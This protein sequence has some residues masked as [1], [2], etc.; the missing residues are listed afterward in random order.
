MKKWLFFLCTLLVLGGGW[1]FL[2][3]GSLSWKDAKRKVLRQARDAVVATVKDSEDVATLAM[4]AISL[5]Q[6]EHG[7]E[8]WRL[9]A[10]W[11]NMRRIDNIM[12]LSNPSLTYIL[13]PENKEITV[14]STRGDI[15][16]KQ[17]VI[18]FVDSV[19][20]KYDNRTLF[21]PLVV[22]TG[23]ERSFS[24]PDGARVTGLG[25]E[26]A[27]GKLSWLL[28]DE[29]LVGEEGVDVTF[30]S[31]KEGFLTAPIKKSQVAE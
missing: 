24:A 10:D 21:A 28:T 22:Y 13:P 29:V 18:R 26:G 9:K 15:D 2:T 27:A 11:G 14:I 20:A 5:T 1:Y 16:E 12:E 17:Q 6:G 7:V 30:E 23:K 25:F 31:D 19:V 3:D 8:L 4:K